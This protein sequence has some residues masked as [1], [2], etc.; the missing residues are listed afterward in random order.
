MKPGLK[1]WITG[2]ST[3]GKYEFFLDLKAFHNVY[4]ADGFSLPPFK[5]ELDR[6]LRDRCSITTTKNP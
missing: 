4:V 5:Q 6:F 3:P 2:Y 1:E